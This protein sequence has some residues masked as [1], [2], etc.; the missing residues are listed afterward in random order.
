MPDAAPEVVDMPDHPGASRVPYSLMQGY[1]GSV[2]AMINKSG[3]KVGTGFLIKLA[4]LGPQQ[5]NLLE[6]QEDQGIITAR[7]C[8]PTKE[9]A[10]S[11]K[12]LFDFVD[13]DSAGKRIDLYPR[14]FFYSGDGKSDWVICGLRDNQP[15]RKPL[16]LGDFT[17]AQLPEQATIHVVSHPKGLPREV[18]HGHITRVDDESV[19]YNA[20]AKAA[21]GSAVFFAANK[22]LHVIALGLK[23]APDSERTHEIIGV[24]A[25]LFKKA[26]DEGRQ[27][28]ANATIIDAGTKAGTKKAEAAPVANAGPTHTG[29][30]RIEDATEKAVKTATGQNITYTGKLK[31]PSNLPHGQGK[32]SYDNGTVYEGGWNNG[33][34]HGPGKI[35]NRKEGYYSTGECE[36]D[37]FIGTWTKYHIN[38]DSFL[39]EQHYDHGPMD[40]MRRN[41][42]MGARKARAIEET[43]PAKSSAPASPAPAS[44]TESAK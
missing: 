2:C 41:L 44:P 42:G 17:D 38:D 43:S 11:F 24:R 32:A 12:A 28:A 10:E 5:A 1:Y 31:V 25:S 19:F 33:K 13:D 3:Q 26:L 4:D 37:L 34:R 18:S 21:I 16:K 39:E 20:G 6:D 36:D 7:Q 35:S 15:D 8:V 22:D 14:K 9:A 23:A 27:P 40:S 29:P 30:S